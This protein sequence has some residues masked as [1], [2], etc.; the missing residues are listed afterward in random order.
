VVITRPER[1]DEMLV[2]VEL[3]A[4][5]TDSPDLRDRIRRS[6]T[7]ALRLRADVDLVPAGTLPAD[8]RKIVDL[9]TWG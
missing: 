1:T 8:A 7:E 3:H 9:R 4:D 6:L 5:A 2:R